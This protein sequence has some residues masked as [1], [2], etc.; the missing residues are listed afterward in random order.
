LFSFGDGMWC[1]SSICIDLVSVNMNLKTGGHITINRN[2][3]QE[4]P[5]LGNGE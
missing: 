5:F 3:G 1:P 2:T 4:R